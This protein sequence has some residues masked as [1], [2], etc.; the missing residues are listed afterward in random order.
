MDAHHGRPDGTDRLQE[1]ASDGHAVRVVVVEEERGRRGDDDEDDLRCGE[2][3]VEIYSLQA[4]LA[5]QGLGSS[6]PK[7]WKPVGSLPCRENS[8]SLPENSGSLPENSGNL[9]ENPGSLLE[10]K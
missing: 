9:P 3:A 1:R 4:N 6:R 5:C 2:P 8:G 7:S 10:L